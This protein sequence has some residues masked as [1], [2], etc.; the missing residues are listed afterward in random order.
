[1]SLTTKSSSVNRK[2]K[3]E[4]LFKHHEWKFKLLGEDDPLFIAKVAYPPPGKNEYFIGVFPSEIRKGKDIY[5]EFTSSDLDVED[6]ERTLYKWRYNPHY[7]EEYEKTEVSATGSFRYLIPVAE[8]V[9][10]QFDEE[11]TSEPALFPNFE[12]IMNPDLDAPLSQMTIR[13]LAAI[14]LSKPVS[15]KSWL[16]DLI[17]NK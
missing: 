5:T 11:P 4:L 13:D 2:E 6:P 15:T 10:I 16:N 8:L 7:E 12:E 1:M 9:K 3:T 17:K 14:M